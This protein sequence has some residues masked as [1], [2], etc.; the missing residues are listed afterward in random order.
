MSKPASVPISTPSKTFDQTLGVK[1]T[2]WLPPAPVQQAA[3]TNNLSGQYCQLKLLKTHHS[4]SLLESFANTPESHWTYLPYGPLV[5]ENDYLIWTERLSEN[6]QLDCFAYAICAAN[7]EEAEKVLGV[8]AYSRILPEHGSIEIGHLS[9]SDKM[10]QTRIATECIFL[11]IEAAFLL[12]Y[13]R[14]EWKCNALN[15]ASKQAAK[16]FGFTHEGT[17]RNAQVLKGRNRDTAWFSII[18]EDWDKLLPAYESWLD[19]KNFDKNGQQ[20]SSLS[21]LTRAALA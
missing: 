20:R 16:R 10:K 14:V 13:R 19:A 9:F 5:T 18:D 8:T 11:M 7:T 21:T 3:L 17:W 12:G 1:V 4:R 6:N 2:A 15:D